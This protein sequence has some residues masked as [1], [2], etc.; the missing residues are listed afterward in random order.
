VGGNSSFIGCFIGSFNAL[1]TYRLCLSSSKGTA[2]IRAASLISGSIGVIF[3]AP[4][5]NLACLF[6]SR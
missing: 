1:K 3:R 4:V 2:G 5:I 6:M